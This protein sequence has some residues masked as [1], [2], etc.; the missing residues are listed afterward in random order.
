VTRAPA[1][2]V[3]EFKHAARLDR[4]RG[5]LPLHQQLFRIL[6]NEILS[7]L[8]K[9]GDFLPAEPELCERYQLSRATVRTALASL[10]EIAL[11][12]RLQGVGTR[13]IGPASGPKRKLVDSQHLSHILNVNRYTRAKVVE[14]AYQ[15]APKAVQGEFRS[16]P[17]ALFQR[18][19]RIRSIGQDPLF[20]IT[21]YLPEAV[22]R[23]FT[24]QDL[25]AT[26]LFEL[27]QRNGIK[28][29][30][31]RQIVS[32][33]AADPPVA[34]YLKLDV[35]VP[36]LNVR[37]VNFDADGRPIEFMELL[38]S[39]DSFELHMTLELPEANG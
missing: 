36:L 9:P 8:V 19:V 12:E 3:E 10:H 16:E 7:G 25:E 26:S 22:G 30:S 23:S 35:G 24:A 39:P 11:I 21:T 33:R 17:G 27:L 32:A 1:G 13:V 4:G 2:P 18:A 31:S 15:T 20:H 29:T 5:K 14:F 34:S 28:L 37:R 38:V 6:R